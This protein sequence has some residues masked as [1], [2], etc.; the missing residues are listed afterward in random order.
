M[1]TRTIFFMKNSLAIPQIVANQAPL[2]MELPSKNTGVGYHFLLQRIFPTQG[3]NSCLLNRQA[4]SLPELLGKPYEKY[5]PSQNCEK[6]GSVFNFS[7]VGVRFNT[8]LAIKFIWVLPFSYLLLHLIY[9]HVNLAKVYE[10]NST[11][12]RYCWKG[13]SL[14]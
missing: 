6:S 9:W 13:R 8:G 3:W 7:L 12:Y 11:S 5:I 1:L 14:F 10:K 4:D 2:S